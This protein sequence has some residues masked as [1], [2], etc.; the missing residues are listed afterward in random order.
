MAAV[1]HQAMAGDVAGVVTGEEHGSS[2]DVELA[3]ANSSEHG[4]PEGHGGLIGIDMVIRLV[5]RD[6]PLESTLVEDPK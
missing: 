5:E 1:D 2:A 3:V 4:R 6:P